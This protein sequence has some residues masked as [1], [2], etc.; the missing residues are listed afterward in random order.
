MMARVGEPRG[1]TWSSFNFNIL[2]VLVVAMSASSR[3][4][5][6]TEIPDGQPARHLASCTCLLLCLAQAFLAVQAKSHCQ[7]HLA[8]EPSFDLGPLPQSLL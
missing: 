3:P 6:V 7:F 1:G 5:R 4:R 8:A 2:W